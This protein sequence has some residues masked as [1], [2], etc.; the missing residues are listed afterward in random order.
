MFGYKLFKED[1]I[2]KIYDE[3]SYINILELSLIGGG[4]KKDRKLRIGVNPDRTDFFI[5]DSRYTDDTRKTVLIHFNMS[6][7]NT[8]IAQLERLRDIDEGIKGN[9]T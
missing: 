8:L 7:I 2:E 1:Y 9:A 5:L 4:N 6:E 3:F